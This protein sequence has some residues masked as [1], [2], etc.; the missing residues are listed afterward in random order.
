MKAPRV[1]VVDTVGAGDSFQ[2]GLLFALR[3][4][5]GIAAR[6]LARLSADQLKRA[7]A[8]AAACAAV[9][10]GRPGADPPLFSE[11]RA[12]PLDALFG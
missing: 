6:S 8:F 2:A 9:T 11:I 12:G 3:A 7:L 4:I 10:C 5:G 1:D